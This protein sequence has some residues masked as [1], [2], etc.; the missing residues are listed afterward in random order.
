MNFRF[1][2]TLCCIL[3]L[4]V[5]FSS[6]FSI[7][8]SAFPYSP[9]PT[10]D[11]P[12]K[13]YATKE[14]YEQQF[15]FSS[16]ASDTYDYF[17]GIATD[18]YHYSR[19]L[20]RDISCAIG[21]TAQDISLPVT[22]TGTWYGALVNSGWNFLAGEAASNYV[23]G[24]TLNFI[25]KDFNNSLNGRHTWDYTNL[26]HG[27]EGIG[28]GWYLNKIG[29]VAIGLAATGVNCYSTWEHMKDNP[30]AGCNPAMELFTNWLDSFGTFTGAVPNPTFSYTSQ[31]AL[32]LS[33]ILRSPEG[34]Y[35]MNFWHDILPGHE[36]VDWVTHLLN[37]GTMDISGGGG[38]EYLQQNDVMGFSYHEKTPEQYM[39]DIYIRRL[40]LY[41]E[42]V[43]DGREKEFEWLRD[44][45]L[46]YQHRREHDNGFANTI[47]AKKPN[48]Y[49]Y[50]T[51]ETE[52]T[53]SFKYPNLLTKSDPDYS[54]GWTVTAYPNGDILDS[55]GNKYGY[56]FY[57]CRTMPS[58]Y[59]TDEGFTVKAE[60]RNE[61][62][63]KV[64][65]AYGM[66]EREIS[67]FIDYW[68]K[69]LIQG[70]DYVMYPILNERVDEIMP[71]ELSVKPDSIFRIWFG[72]KHSNGEAVKE[73]EIT[74]IVR[75][76]FTAVEWG[77]SVLD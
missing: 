16:I 74:P 6:F 55:G 40:N 31:G 57:E 49:L 34:V 11:Y 19:D 4:T 3:A 18:V 38:S 29:G 51:D 25:D 47:E 65:S 50:P 5:I 9:Y 24:W 23:G 69:Y 15:T 10:S 27:A 61:T 1:K 70:D 2:K 45:L 52:L 30:Y 42:M 72:F 76:G 71:L 22:D 66:N 67:D 13:R 41:A 53:V 7:T 43:K 73:P 46:D 12:Y 77:G 33:N 26:G 58:N 75:E 32:L 39:D 68:S 48:I 36:F 63:R 59:Q 35:A 8:A 62:F 21:Q 56:L 14:E 44:W 17:A 20:V 60:S 54:N 28:K 64:L 37:A